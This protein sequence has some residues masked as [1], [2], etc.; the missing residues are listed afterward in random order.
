M[1]WRAGTDH[2]SSR[3]RL[4]VPGDTHRQELDAA[5]ADVHAALG[6]PPRPLRVRVRSDLPPAAGMGSSAALAVALARAVAD[7]AALP[8]S[9]EEA[10]RVAFETERRFHG[11]A[12]GIDNTTAAWG[13]PLAFRPGA[14][15]EPLEVGG[16]FRFLWVHSGVTSSTRD[17]VAAVAALRDRDPGG[18]EALFDE[19]AATVAS[20]RAAIARG[21]APSLAAALTSNQAHLRRLGVSHPAI[22]AVITRAL[23]WGAPAAKLTGAGRG[24]MV[25]VLAPDDPEPLRRAFPGAV[26]GV[27]G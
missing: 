22:E 9:R 10:S 6:V 3:V 1:E 2:P 16:P 18:T 12:S 19:I 15:P 14:P 5:L 13:I 20:G 21:D 25:L 24:G 17:A 11:R 26:E 27:L 7:A 8:L 23:A 4:F